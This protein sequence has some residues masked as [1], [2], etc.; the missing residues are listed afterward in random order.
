MVE[1]PTLEAGSGPTEP[2]RRGADASGPNGLAFGK[3]W[4][5]QDRWL[6]FVDPVLERAYRE[7]MTGPTRRRFRVA[8]V[9]AWLVIATLPLQ[10]VALFG[11]VAPI[12]VAASLG[13]AA[14]IAAVAVWA[15]RV[16]LRGIWGLSVGVSA[17]VAIAIVVIWVA[18]DYVVPFLAF[19]LASIFVWQ[20]AVLRVAWWVAAAM[21]LGGTALFTAVALGVG[22]EGGTAAFQ[23]VLS[24]I[25][26]GGAA[27]GSW[28][29][30]SAE[31]RSFAQG[32]LVDHQRRLID[33]L[34]R[35]YLSPDVAQALVE[36][37]GRAELGGEVV[38]VSVLF[39]DLRGY[40]PFAE[41][42]APDE[43]VAMLN[44]AFG[45]AVPAVFA[46]GG[47]I[48]SFVGDAL[49][50]IFN[51]PLRQPDHALRACRAALALQAAASIDPAGDGRP[52]FRV[53]INTGPALV[54][55]IGSPELRNFSALGDTTN[56]AAR[57][58][59]YASEGSI[60]IGAR[61]YELV[62]DAVEVRSLGA[63]ELKGKSAPTPVFELVAAG[64]RG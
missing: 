49:M 45:S 19:G 37:P 52:R 11:D 58:Q 50:A 31:R 32:L 15:G 35:Q 54:G 47:T 53:G 64:Q 46:E 55:N 16:G 21:F 28:F 6:R 2:A 7:A 39:A 29:L 61:T 36:D 3:G 42:R 23:I 4:D 9:I 44:T 26:L 63:V 17:F 18:E 1:G 43:V 13:S 27:L 48:V 59:T 10:I 25:V 60:V 33:H 24:V 62:R 40:T 38:E 22:V 56:V 14:V 51:A 5:R 34:F 57:L 41:G 12:S 20:I 8:S 30:E